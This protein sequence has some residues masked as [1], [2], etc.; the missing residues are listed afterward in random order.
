MIGQAMVSLKP[1]RPEFRWGLLA[2]ILIVIAA[3]FLSL[4]AIGFALSSMAFM[5]I[6]MV[7]LGYRRWPVLVAVAILTPLSI[8]WAFYGWLQV[9]VPTS[10]FSQVF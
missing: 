3:Y 7:L 9:P 5:M 8:W 10:P 1:D 6:F 2:A 4:K